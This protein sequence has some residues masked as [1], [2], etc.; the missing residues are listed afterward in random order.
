MQWLRSAMLVF[1]VYLLIAVM[2]ILGAP[3]APP[4]RVAG[5]GD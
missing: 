4:R 2:G 1:L 3:V 5:W